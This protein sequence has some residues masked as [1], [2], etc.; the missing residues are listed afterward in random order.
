MQDALN[1]LMQKRTSLII[2]HRL[3]TIQNVDEI[4]VLDK[5]NIVERGRHDVLAS[6]NGLYKKLLDMQSFE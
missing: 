3:S 5:G 1:N 2:A 4:I 6:G